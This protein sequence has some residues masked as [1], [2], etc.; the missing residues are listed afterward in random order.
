MATVRS[1]RT[2]HTVQTSTANPAAS[3]HGDSVRT[4]RQ[5]GRELAAAASTSR[6]HPTARQARLYTTAARVRGHG[7]KV[8]FVQHDGP[9][10][11]DFEP[12]TAGWA[13]LGSVTQG[14]GDRVVHK[15]LKA[16][17]VEVGST[18]W[19]LLRE[20]DVLGKLVS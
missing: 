8:V 12:Y 2:M 4:D 14:P 11:D 19:S 5:L 20:D 6:H 18:K 13:I 15:T 7:G 3:A 17:I 10:G 9:A 16:T 1:R